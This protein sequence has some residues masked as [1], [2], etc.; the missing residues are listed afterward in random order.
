MIRKLSDYTQ[1][2]FIKVEATQYTEI[3]YHGKDVDTIINDLFKKTSSET[4]SE[5]QTLKRNLKEEFED[6]LDLV[7]LEL[8][9]GH[10]PDAKIRMQKLSE[11][12]EG[13][14][15]QRLLNVPKDLLKSGEMFE[16]YQDYFDYLREIYS[17]ISWGW[18]YETQRTSVR[19][20][21]YELFSD[22]VNN[23]E[24]HLRESSISI[25]KIQNDGIVF[26]DEIDKIAVGKEQRRNT[27]S[28]STDGVQRDLL[29]IVEGT[30]IK[31]SGDFIDT[32]HILFI[33]AGAFSSASVED[34]M[35]EFLGTLWL[36]QRAFPCEDISGNAEEEGI[37]TNHDRSRVRDHRP[38][39]GPLANRKYPFR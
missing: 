18:D 13:H 5:I 36:T 1:S 24:G 8:V 17:K 4:K 9:V 39:Q 6:F 33:C 7:I 14:F 30:K 38:V 22:L 29:P 3:G 19:K 26:I 10:Q 20:L 32:S 11:I 2:P 21:K 23:L 37:Y 27:K 12:R 28:P 35:P 25:N 34:L 16:S 15:D 31:V